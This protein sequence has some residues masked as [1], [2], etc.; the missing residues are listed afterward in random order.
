MD[1]TDVTVRC[2]LEAMEKNESWAGEDMI[3]ASVSYL[4]RDTYVYT[5]SDKAGVSPLAYS[6]S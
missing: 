4:K 6:A 3:V 5:Y 2:H 1:I